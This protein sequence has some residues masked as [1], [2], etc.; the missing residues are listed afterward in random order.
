VA[1]ALL[2]FSWKPVLAFRKGATKWLATVLSTE[3]GRARAL[4]TAFCTIG[5]LET[6]KVVKIA[7]ETWWAIGRPVA[8][9]GEIGI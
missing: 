8:I 3:T 9:D 1:L 6:R 4:A 7:V 5:E 2:P